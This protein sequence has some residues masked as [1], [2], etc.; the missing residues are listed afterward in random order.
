MAELDTLLVTN[1]T[2]EDF[3]FRFNGELYEP[4]PAGASKSYPGFLAFFAAKH[5]SEKMLQP[6]RVKLISAEEK[7]KGSPYVPAVSILMN[8]D[9]VTRRKALYDIL[10]GKQLVENCIITM[11]LKSFVGVMS[12]Y[13]EYVVKQESPKLPT[14]PTP[15][16]K[17][18]K[19]KDE[20]KKE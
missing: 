5:L 14:P 9:N 4:I 7:A 17:A 10:G 2:K 3:Q 8:H 18:A 11:N 20:L 12:E 19:P 15:S 13:D 1:P 16:T 6:E